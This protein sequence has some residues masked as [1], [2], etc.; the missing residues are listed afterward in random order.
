MSDDPTSPDALPFEEAQRQLDEVIEQLES[1]ELPLEDSLALYERG[2]ALVRRCRLLLDEAER[3][4]VQIV[5][6]RELPLADDE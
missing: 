3:R 4:V 6:E 2:V 1:R 5:G